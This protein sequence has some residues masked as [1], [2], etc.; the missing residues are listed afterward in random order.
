[1]QG[2]AWPESQPR[3]FAS[4]RG[5]GPGLIRF[6][7]A[8]MEIISSVFISIPNSRRLRAF[9]PRRTSQ[10]SFWRREMH[11]RHLQSR[12]NRRS[13]GPDPLSR[14][15]APGG[16]VTRGHH[17][18]SLGRPDRGP[19]PAHPPPSPPHLREGW[20]LEPGQLQVRVLVPAGRGRTQ[21]RPGSWVTS[22]DSSWPP[23]PGLGNVRSQNAARGRSGDP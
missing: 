4:R 8:G 3:S 5:G 6:Y 17:L 21:P 14:A 19:E 13:P 20:G 11:P 2:S 9:Q 10:Q 16:A 1:M 23:R 7:F 18:T 12:G 22:L 15:R